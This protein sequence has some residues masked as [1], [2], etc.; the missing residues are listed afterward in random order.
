MSRLQRLSEWIG[1]W[2]YPVV[3]ILLGI[4]LA[5]PSLLVGIQA[6][7]LFIRSAIRGSEQFSDISLSPWQ[8]YMYMDGDPV[9]NHVLIDHGW[10]PWW[11]DLHCRAALSRPLTALTF[12][13]DYYA[14]PDHP[15]LM[16]VQSLMWYGLL[17]WAV[18]ILYRRIIAQ[19]L[20]YWVAVLATLLYA[21]DDAHGIPAGWLA[22]R[23]A[24]IAAFFGVLTLILHD[25]WR[26]DGWR[27]G[28]WLAPLAFLTALL[29][30]EEAVSTGGYLFAYALFLD[31][32]RW[33]HR[34]AV[35]APCLLAG[36]V[37]RLQVARLRSVRFGS[38]CRSG[39][40]PATV[41]GPSGGQRSDPASGAV[42]APA[43]GY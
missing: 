10:M 32:G 2:R 30:K 9:R 8:P 16:H 21:V 15:A 25:R 38:L 5:A 33:P 23:N 1:R 40:R 42:G 27:V 20:P 35:L 19:S 7:D 18:A 41:H 11:M 22:N 4:L 37:R 28:V 31:R 17:I 13:W 3:P 43:V 6:D 34:L 24:P 14:W 39:Q 26:R 29:A 12:M 36:L